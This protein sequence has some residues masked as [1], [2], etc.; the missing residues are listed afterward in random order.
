MTNLENGAGRGRRGAQHA[1]VR[2]SDAAFLTSS[3]VVY[4]ARGEAA[5]ATRRKRRGCCTP[6]PAPVAFGLSP[7]THGA[8]G[9]DEVAM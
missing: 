8:K 3:S 7:A 2:Y 6:A 4:T 1:A 5:P 9:D